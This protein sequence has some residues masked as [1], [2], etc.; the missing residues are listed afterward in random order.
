MVGR[1]GIEARQRC[2]ASSRRWRS[3]V[4]ATARP[5]RYVASASSSSGVMVRAPSSSSVGQFG[6]A[7]T[8]GELATK[9]RALRRETGV[10]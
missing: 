10:P 1:F 7:L 2:P 3:S 5:L 4:A 9:Q 8:G 6:R